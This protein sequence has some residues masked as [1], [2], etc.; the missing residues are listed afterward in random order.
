VL[1]SCYRAAPEPDPCIRDL[2][3]SETI[4]VR[5]RRTARKLLDFGIAKMLPDRTAS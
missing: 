4:L 3:P 5:A 2:K 1:R